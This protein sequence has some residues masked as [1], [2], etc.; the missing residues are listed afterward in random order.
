MSNSRTRRSDTEWLA[1]ISECRRSG[2]SDKIWCEE[3]NIAISSFYNAV[4]RL[5]KKACDIPKAA[6]DRRIVDLTSKKQDVVQIDIVPDEDSDPVIPTCRDT[7]AVH[8]DNSHTI[9]LKFDN[10]M[11]MRI[12]NQADPFLLEKV[13]C[14]VRRLS[15]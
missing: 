11:S 2:L 5:R 4:T 14:M 9:E 8:L 6:S 15:C 3:R 7:A 12:S 13:L 10:G 1:L